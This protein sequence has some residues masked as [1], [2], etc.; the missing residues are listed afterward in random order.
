MAGHLVQSVRSSFVQLGGQ[1]Q[2]LGHGGGQ[3]ISDLWGIQERIHRYVMK[4]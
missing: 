2:F 4:Y 3:C 1:I